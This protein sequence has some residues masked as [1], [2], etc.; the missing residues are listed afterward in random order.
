MKKVVCAE[1]SI[2]ENHSE[3]PWDSTRV[4][5]ET[6]AQQADIICALLS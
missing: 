5:N 6:L 3:S 4:Y 1:V 2:F